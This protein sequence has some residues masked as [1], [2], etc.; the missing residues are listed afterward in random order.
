MNEPTFVLVEAAPAPAPLG[1]FKLFIDNV[2]FV[3]ETFELLM[4]D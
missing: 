1:V 2:L 3:C 4:S